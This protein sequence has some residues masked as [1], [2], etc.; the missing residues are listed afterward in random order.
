MMKPLRWVRFQ[1]HRCGYLMEEALPLKTRER[2]ADLRLR[3]GKV[4]KP[5][6]EEIKY[7]DL[8]KRSEY[9]TAS[10]LKEIQL[11]KFKRLIA[12]AYENVPFYHGTMNQLG[13]KP[14]D[15]NAL[16]DIVKLPVIT[17]EDIRKEP[18]RFISQNYTGKS[19]PKLTRIT[20]GGST[21]TPMS[22][23][24]DSKM[25]AVRNAHWWR[26][27]AF[28]GVD[29]YSDRMMFIGSDA[30]SRYRNPRNFKGVLNPARTKLS[31][32]SNSM[33][34]RV[35]DRYI[36]SMAEF[37]G[38]YFRGFA[39]AIYLIARRLI[40]RDMRMPL[41]AVLTS[42]DTL[43]EQYRKVI[44]EAFQCEVFDHYGMNEDIITA[45]ECSAHDGFHI[46]VESTFTE[47]V[48]TKGEPVT[49]VE[50]LLVGT[51]LENYSMPLIRY[52]TGDV[53][54]LDSNWEQCSCGRCHQKIKELTGRHRDTIITPDGRRVASLVMNQPLVTM[55]GA[56]VKCQFIQ[57]SLDLLVAKIVPTREWNN[58]YHK[59]FITCLKREV[60]HVIKIQVELVDDIPTQENGKYRLI[61]SKIEDQ[62]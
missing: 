15:F 22:Y 49:G 17:K 11:E 35:I 61:V 26:W 24:F 39:S 2:R 50:G 58:K 60:G 57:E 31:L 28:A 54:N 62:L 45:T 14:S 37:K 10:E 46:N 19:D 36:A 16:E 59:E 7:I 47:T 13:L 55:A 32:T 12:H 40:D 42:S 41:K 34:N 27:S 56:M 48:D 6:S 21:G 30:E 18:H 51:H 33:G 53:G 25:V 8:L 43:F 44:E 4:Y 1:I 20:T 23:Y 52:M 3:K 38:D 29:L 5:A 9:C